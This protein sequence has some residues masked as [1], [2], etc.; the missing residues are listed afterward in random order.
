VRNCLTSWC[1]DPGG[2]T[3]S[4]GRADQ[5]VHRQGAQ[6]GQPDAAFRL[7]LQFADHPGAS[8]FAPVASSL[9][10]SLAG[11]RSAAAVHV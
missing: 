6:T 2:L 3:G 4:G 8:E 7:L 10:G 9:V 5:A 11:Q 1:A